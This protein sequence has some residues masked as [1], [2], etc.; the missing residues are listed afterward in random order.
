MAKEKSAS[1]LAKK[2]ANRS[3]N[4]R[5]A[6]DNRLTVGDL[7]IPARESHHVKV[8]TGRD[9]KPFEVT[10]TKNVRPSKLIRSHRRESARRSV[11]A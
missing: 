7:N 1:V 11:V 10:I 9:G 8:R 6:E 4:A 3:A 2:E 5:R